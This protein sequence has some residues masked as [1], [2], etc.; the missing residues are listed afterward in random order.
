ML[1]KLAFLKNIFVF[2]WSYIAEMVRGANE[3]LTAKENKKIL[4]GEEGRAHTKKE[5]VKLLKKSKY[6]LVDYNSLPTY[7]KDNEFI[8]DYYRSEWP[9]KQIF[10]SVFS[11]HNETLNVWTHLIGFFLFLFL[12]ICTAMK[13]PMV[14]DSLQHLPEIIGKADLNKIH[15]ELLKC[16]PSLPSIPDLDKVKNELMTSLRSFNFSSLSGWNVMEHLTRCLHDKFSIGLNDEK[17]DFLS[18]SLV[19]PI[20]RLPFYAFLAGAMFCLLASST[21]HLLACHSQRLSYILLRIDYAGIAVLIATSF[22]PP[23]YYSFMCNPFFCYLYLGFITLMGVATIVFSL[24][25]FFQK[26]EFRKYRASLFFLMGFSGVAPV[27]HKLILYRHE[28]EALQTTGYE[29]LMGVLYGLGAAIYVAR[30]P[31][32]WM[33]GKFDIAGNSHQLFHVFVVAGAYTHYL[34]GLIYLRWRD[35][36][37]C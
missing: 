25:P 31:E 29:V 20:T 17:M 30:I 7:L 22:Y 19:Q 5:R 24:L 12:T 28:P 15:A 23:V 36:R 37:G 8:L 26:S 13:A 27:M 1:L 11:I 21:C 4:N 35:L 16:L 3:K 34:D 32:R 14:M 33:P 2:C 10:L 6:Q 18:P 9:L